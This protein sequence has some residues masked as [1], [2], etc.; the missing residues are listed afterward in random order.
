M[1]QNH[2]QGVIDHLESEVSGLSLETVN[3]MEQSMIKV[4]LCTV[5]NSSTVVAAK[6]HMQIKCRC[7]LL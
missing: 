5:A 6:F 3:S 2:L 7:T 1:K 4:Q